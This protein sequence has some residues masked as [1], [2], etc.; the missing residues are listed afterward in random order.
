[1]LDYVIIV[2]VFFAGDITQKGFEKKR[3]KL[4]SQYA[5]SPSGVAGKCSF[6]EGNYSYMD[7][8]LPMACTV[9]LA[10]LGRHFWCL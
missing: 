10:D 3:S 7:L 4:L 5:K 1:M 2:S 6:F 9:L 8:A